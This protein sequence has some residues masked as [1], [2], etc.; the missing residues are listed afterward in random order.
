MATDRRF[1]PVSQFGCAEDGGCRRV[2]LGLP[3][4]ACGTPGSGQ[5]FCDVRAATGSPD[6]TV[7]TAAFVQA[8]VRDGKALKLKDKE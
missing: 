5:S 2:R 4:D 8:I 6:P 3:L 7:R 1:L